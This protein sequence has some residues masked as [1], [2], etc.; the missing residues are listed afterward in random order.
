MKVYYNCQII[1][2]NKQIETAGAL[3]V[4]NGRI[5]ELYHSKPDIEAEYIDLKGNFV[6]PGFIDTHTHSA[7]GGLYSMGENLSGS[8]CLAEVFGRLYTAKPLG[9]KVIAWHLDETELKEKRFPTA[10]ELDWIYPDKEVLIRRVD[11][12]SCVINTKAAKQIAAIQ[13]LR[14]DFDGTFR[15]GENDQ[16]VNWFHSSIDDETILKS[17]K[18]AATQAIKYGHTTIHTMVGDGHQSL[19]HYEL[20][21]ANLG[22]YPVEFILYPQCFNIDAALEVGAR[23][24]GGCILA[25]GSFGSHTAGLFEPYTDQQDNYGVLYHEDEHWKRIISRA[26]AEN[27]QF[28]VHCIGDRAISQILKFYEMVQKE[29]PKDLRH[30]LIHNELTS[31]EMIVRMGKSNIVAAMQPMFDRLWAGEGG[32]Y[33][34]VL[35]KE[36]TA[37]TNRLRSLRDSGVIIGGGSDWYVT[38][39]DALAGIDAAVRMHNPAERL[40]AY[41]AIELYTS[42]AAYIS[43]DEDR[44][45]QLAPGFQA[46]F[47]VLEKSPLEADDIAGIKII[48]VFKKGE[49]IS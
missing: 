27:L 37:R 8:D 49:C 26:H 18:N 2:M 5:V 34:H 17:Y 39:M 15:R 6:L 11:G 47:V 38:E 31:D 48:D 30:I 36:R 24:L 41:E 1:T 12:H 21:K 44:I 29:D 25:D 33:E 3:A 32:L 20:I 9:N 14:T 23:R 40:T 42:K 16:I 22:N 4:E 45:G 19:G 28:A 13:P 43:H 46:D 10:K 7:S 35:G